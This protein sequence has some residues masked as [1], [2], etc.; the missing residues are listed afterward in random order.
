MA[1]SD[2][3]S[4]DLAMR[5]TGLEGLFGTGDHLKPSSD[6]IHTALLPQLPVAEAATHD[7]QKCALGPQRSSEENQMERMQRHHK[8]SCQY[9]N[10]AWG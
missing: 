10:S 3:G 2:P 4:V 8:N 9:S 6:N 1:I 7:L 5:L